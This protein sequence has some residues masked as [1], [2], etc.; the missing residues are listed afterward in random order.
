MQLAAFYRK[1]EDTIKSKKDNGVEEKRGA[2]KFKINHQ[3]SY[4]FVPFMLPL[5]FVLH[6]PLKKSPPLLSK[7]QKE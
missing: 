3:T 4:N 7:L 6:G 5:L 1:D 2:A